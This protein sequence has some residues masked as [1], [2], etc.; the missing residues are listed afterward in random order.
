MTFRFS[1]SQSPPAKFIPPFATHL[2]LGN[3]PASWRNGGEMAAMVTRFVRWSFAPNFRSLCPCPNEGSL[4]KLFQNQSCKL[5]RIHCTARRNQLL[6]LSQRD[7]ERKS[8][9][10]R[11][12]WQMRKFCTPWPRT[13][14]FSSSNACASVCMCVCVLLCCRS[15]R[16]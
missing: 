16:Q 12:A 4:S 10:S 2:I 5:S 6:S 9:K 14:F 11:L 15:I 1:V 7:R 13:L 8:T 3:P